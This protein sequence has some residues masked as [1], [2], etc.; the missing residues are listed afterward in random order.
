MTPRAYLL[1]WGNN[2]A[3]CPTIIEAANFISSQRNQRN[4]LHLV[5]NPQ[6]ALR[7]EALYMGMLSYNPYNGLP[8]TA[9]MPDG[10]RY[11]FM[12]NNI[13]LNPINAGKHSIQ[14]IQALAPT[15]DEH[16][17]LYAAKN[18]NRKAEELARAKEFR[19]A[20]TAELYTRR[21]GW[22]AVSLEFE[23]WTWD[24]D[25][26]IATPC[27]YTGNIVAKDGAEAY[28]KM[29]RDIEADAEITPVR[30]LP[31]EWSPR[32]QPTFLGLKTDDGYSIEAWEA[33]R[34]NRKA[35]DE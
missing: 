9:I 11:E 18:A 13:D 2:T 3:F 28:R 33:Y 26:D 24:G 32:Y 29:V 8:Q 34:A 31:S 17:R 23:R 25:K 22:W 6:T 5:I 14:V 30:Q 12:S 27:T 21:R 4:G 15:E 19:K 20:R 7:L 10:S 1:K 16:N 35:I